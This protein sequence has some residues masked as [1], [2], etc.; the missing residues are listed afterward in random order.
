MA[1]IG[2][3]EIQSR[4]LTEARFSSRGGGESRRPTNKTV[5][6]AQLPAPG[7][8]I[9]SDTGTVPSGDGRK[10]HRGRQ[11][12]G[13]DKA[14]RASIPAVAKA[15][16]DSASHR[17]TQAEV[18]FG[19]R[20]AT[21][22]SDTARLPQGR[23]PKSIPQPP[24]PKTSAA[25]SETTTHQYRDPEKRKAYMAKYMRDRRA[26]LRAEREKNSQAEKRGA[27]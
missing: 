2:P 20:E 1:K 5:T 11:R 14:S 22:S 21:A 24:S 15:T 18:A 13:S 3:K 19:P 25:V 7:M 27:K 4:A 12:K 8:G 26:R 17:S 10:L 16:E 6:S 9:R 23:K